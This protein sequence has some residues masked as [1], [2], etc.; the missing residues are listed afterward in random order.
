MHPDFRR[1]GKIN[2]QPRSNVFTLQTERLYQVTQLSSRPNTNWEPTPYIKTECQDTSNSTTDWKHLS[3]TWHRQAH[4]DWIQTEGKKLAQTQS[5][6]RI[7]TSWYVT[8]SLSYIFIIIYV[9]QLESWTM[10]TGHNLFFDYIINIFLWL[11]IRTKSKGINEIKFSSDFIQLHIIESCSHFLW[12]I[13]FMHCRVKN[14][15]Y[16]KCIATCLGHY[17]ALPLEVFL[18]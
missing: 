10:F 13:W 14:T 5:F 18:P 15:I 12:I 1:G 7:I 16:T 11:Y 2:S 8:Q 17:T 4:E 3:T 6:N 9:R